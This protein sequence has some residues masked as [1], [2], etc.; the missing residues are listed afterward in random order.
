MKV[1][2]EELGRPE[3]VR[4]QNYILSITDIDDSEVKK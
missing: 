2:I 4:G 3:Q 1:L